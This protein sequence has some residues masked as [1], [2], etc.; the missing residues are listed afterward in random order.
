M[1]FSCY[2]TEIGIGARSGNINPIETPENETPLKIKYRKNNRCYRQLLDV[3]LSLCKP[4]LRR[5]F[6]QDLSLDQ[7]NSAT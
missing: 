2:A 4:L 3:F 6:S 7:L 1:F 5:V